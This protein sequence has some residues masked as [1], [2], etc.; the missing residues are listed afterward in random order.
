MII[1]FEQN[2]RFLI[3]GNAKNRQIVGKL[4]ENC[5]K[6]LL[7]SEQDPPTCRICLGEES[8]L[9][10]FVSPCNCRGTLRF[11]HPTC[12]KQWIQTSG[13]GRCSTCRQNYRIPLT[14]GLYLMD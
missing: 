3:I 9:G 14:I 1:I 11:V 8:D 13:R 7:K 5:E 4:M 10:L 6:N 2:I 12:L